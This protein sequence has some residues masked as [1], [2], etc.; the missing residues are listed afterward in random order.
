MKKLI[1]MLA[2]VMLVGGCASLISS[3]QK[4]INLRSEPEK[5]KI[6]IWDDTGRIIYRGETPSQIVLRTGGAYFHGHDYIVLIC[7]QD[8]CRK[9]LLQSQ[10][11]GWYL[12]N[13]LFG[14]VIGMGIIDPLTGAMWTIYN[15]DIYVDF[16]KSEPTKA[17]KEGV[18]VPRPGSDTGWG[19]R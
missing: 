9:T 16:K 4:L 1:A 2:V 12:G 6:T 14:G 7:D 18:P 11:N 13:I 5:A 19:K 15:R 17:L 10:V 3:N 8:A